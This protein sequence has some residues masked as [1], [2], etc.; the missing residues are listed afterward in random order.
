MFNKYKT[1]LKLQMFAEDNIDDTEEVE[2]GNLPSTSE[3]NI[4]PEDDDKEDE[5]V[6]NEE[7]ETEDEDEEELDKKTK[8]LIRYKQEAK[9]SK[10]KL[11]ELQE[12]LQA[13]QLKNDKE[14]RITELKKSGVS[15][16]IAERTAEAESKTKMYE[17]R[18]AKFEYADLEQTY[19]NISNHREGIEELK[20][21][22]PDLSREELYLAKF[23]KNASF[24]KRRNMEAE[25]DYK[26]RIAKN[27]SFVEGTESSKANVKLTR[28]E[29]VAYDEVK[30]S[31]P[32]MTR[33]QFYKSLNE[34]EELDF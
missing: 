19:P 16:D 34:E 11:E 6:E 22:Y 26:Q 21:K 15:E 24:E 28:A 25:L 10:K 7:L 17:T 5:G 20:G 14:K 12:R 29:R 13:D 18:L 4:P 27:K 9:E 8:A 3:D 32:K 31:N 2:D 23:S 30:K 33:E 1:K